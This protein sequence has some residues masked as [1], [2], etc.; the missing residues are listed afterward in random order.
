M[1]ESGGL[2]EKLFNSA[3]NAKRQAIIKGNNSM[4]F[5]EDMCPFFVWITV[6]RISSASIVKHRIDSG[7][8]TAY[9]QIMRG[10]LSR[11]V[12]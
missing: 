7:T 11:K 3:Y 6:M 8:C 9:C 2:K 1:K 4:K 12:R 10:L 5:C